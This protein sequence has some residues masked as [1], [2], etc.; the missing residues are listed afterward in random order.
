VRPPDDGATHV[1][2]AEPKPVKIGRGYVNDREVA[3]RHFAA[4]GGCKR[5]ETRWAVKKR[6][7]AAA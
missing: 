5:V 2:W 6:R 7:L 3:K 4:V 1:T